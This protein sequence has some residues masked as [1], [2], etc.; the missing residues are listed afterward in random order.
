MLNKT[1]E[2]IKKVASQSDSL[3]LFHSA[4]GKD[5]IALLDLC[6]PYFKQITCVFM[7]IVKDLKHTAKYIEW[8]KS[9]YHGVKFIEF[10]H[11]ALASYIKTGHMG[12][13]KDPKQK[14]LSLADINERARIYTGTEWTIMGFKQSDSMNRRLMLRTYEDNIINTPTKKAY[15]LSEWRNKDVLRYIKMKGLI[16]PIAYGSAQSQ[17]TAVENKDFVLWCYKNY[18]E[19]YQKIIKTFPEAEVIVFEYLNK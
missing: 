4:A 9:K 19:D 18:P 12:I 7:Y 1:I 3:I 11:Y 17:G 13:K 6:Y 14:L 2:A 16:N 5:S 10:P 15:P 8:A